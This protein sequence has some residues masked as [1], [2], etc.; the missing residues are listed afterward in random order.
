MSSADYSSHRIIRCKI[1]E[2]NLGP[3]M[4]VFYMYSVGTLFWYQAPPKYRG[5]KKFCTGNIPKKIPTISQKNDFQ[6]R[7]TMMYVG[8]CSLRQTSI[9]LWH[10]F[11]FCFNF[12]NFWFVMFHY[13]FNTNIWLT[14][15]SLRYVDEKAVRRHSPAWHQGAACGRQRGE[16][17]YSI[18]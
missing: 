15:T 4:Q 14:E 9:W 7:N 6:N 1:A 11:W 18:S 3:R 10:V 13:C 5:R 8:M 16:S 2:S 17:F 12:D